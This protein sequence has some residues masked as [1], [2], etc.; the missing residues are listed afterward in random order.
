[1]HR[2][3]LVI[4]SKLNLKKK[5]GQKTAENNLGNP[6]NATKTKFSKEKQGNVQSQFF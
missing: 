5:N 1:M 2:H 3:I 4:A 6:L